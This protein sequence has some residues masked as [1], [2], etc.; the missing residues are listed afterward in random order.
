MLLPS[1]DVLL[2]LIELGANISSSWT[3][4]P[5]VYEA[6]LHGSPECL[7]VLLDKL[8]DPNDDAACAHVL[9]GAFAGL[10]V[11][12]I[13]LLLQHNSKIGSGTRFQFFFFCGFAYACFP[14]PCSFIMSRRSSHVC[15]EQRELH[16]GTEQLF[17]AS[18][19]RSQ[20]KDDQMCANTRLCVYFFLSALTKSPTARAAS[21]ESIRSAMKVALGRHM[22]SPTLEPLLDADISLAGLLD[23]AIKSY[24]S[25]GRDSTGALL[26]FLLHSNLKACAEIAKHFL[27]RGA[28]PNMIVSE[29][30]SISVF[31]L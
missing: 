28:D 16:L 20:R 2:E 25:Y 14:F 27:S 8:L 15:S 3:G 5:I 4:K 23:V 6:A 9:T 26:F 10:N 19:H 31:F 1:P 21:P 13:L 22:P 7:K 30:L 24:S 12:N 18:T 11:E 29:S 17:R